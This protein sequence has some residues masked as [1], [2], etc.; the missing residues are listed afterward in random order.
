MK[1]AFVL[2]F[3]DGMYY[4]INDSREECPHMAML[5]HYTAAYRIQE[6]YRDSVTYPEIVRILV[7]D[8]AEIWGVY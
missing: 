1:P 4:Q 6:T 2:R 8:D 5:M 7:D 3:P